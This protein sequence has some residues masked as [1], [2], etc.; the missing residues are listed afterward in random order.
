MRLNH[1]LTLL[2][3][4]LTDNTEQGEGSELP[5]VLA[6]TN[7][8]LSSA[9]Y[10]KTGISCRRAC[11][12]PVCLPKMQ[13]LHLPSGPFAFARCHSMQHQNPGPKIRRKDGFEMYTV[14]C[15]RCSSNHKGKCT[16]H[17]I[18]IITHKMK[19]D[20]HTA[21]IRRIQQRVQNACIAKYTADQFLVRHGTAP[22]Q[23]RF[24]C[25]IWRASAGPP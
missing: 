23:P 17:Q 16:V 3:G 22:P 20:A 8:I 12:T 5:T 4:H 13:A 18:R 10:A 9:R 24:P 25:C 21:S 1:N 6:V 19:S 15:N 2:Q 7:T 14:P 11:Q